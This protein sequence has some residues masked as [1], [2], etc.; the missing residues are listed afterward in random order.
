MIVIQKNILIQLIKN[1]QNV[2]NT[3]PNSGEKKLLQMII[4]ELVLI[5]MLSIITK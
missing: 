5:F 2:G 3:V 4:K 1:A